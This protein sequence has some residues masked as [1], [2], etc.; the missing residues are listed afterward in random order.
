MHTKLKQAGVVRGGG[1]RHLQVLV[2]FNLSVHVGVD[3]LQ[4]LVQLLTGHVR[5]SEV[6]K[7]RG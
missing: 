7:Q 2:Q 1:D 5:L 4:D 6:L 3:L